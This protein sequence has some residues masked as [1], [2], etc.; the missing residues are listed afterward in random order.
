MRGG[1]G[2]VDVDVAQGGEFFAEGLVVLLLLGMES[3]VLQQDDIPRAHRRNR[4]LRDLADA[5][6]DEGDLLAQERGEPL[7]GGSEAHL[8]HLLSLRAAQVGE[9]DRLPAVR[10]GVP[11]GGDRRLDPRVVGN[12]PR[13]VQ[14]HV[15]IDADQH[16]LP[17]KIQLVD[18]AV[19]HR[20]SLRGGISW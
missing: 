15:E 11:D 5:V 14:R 1:E 8:R 20:F 13:L 6:G 12:V 3:D 17:G 4:L 9:Q 7:R 16:P 19:L 10:H 2:V 18:G